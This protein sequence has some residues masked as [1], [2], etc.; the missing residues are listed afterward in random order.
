MNQQPTK[1]VR[2]RNPSS[3]RPSSLQVVLL[4]TVVIAVA[5]IALS[6]QAFIAVHAFSVSDPQSSRSVSKVLVTGAAGKT[7]RLVLSKLEQDPRYEP[8]ALVR[9]ERSAR[10]LVYNIKENRNADG[11]PLQHCPLEHILI[12]DIT[13]PTFV[14]TTSQI[15]GLVHDGGIEAMIICTSSVPQIQKRSVIKMLLKAPINILRR[16]PVVDFRSLTFRWK[17]G[18]RGY[19]QKVD[20]DGQ[21]AQIQLAKALGIRHVVLVS[22]MGVT[23][24][25]NFLNSVGKNNNGKKK[26]A[27]AGGDGD[28]GHGDILIWKRRA[29][30][31]LVEESG[32]D[33][34]IIHPG[35]L[36]DTPGG[37]EEFVLDVD[38]NL[39]NQTGVIRKTRIS[40]EDVADLCVAALSVGKNRKVSFDCITRPIFTASDDDDDDDDIDSTATITAATKTTTR[41]SAE[42]ALSK[43]LELSKTADYA[44]TM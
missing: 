35:G 12:A 14:E 30:K 21:I 4:A 17:G 1:T 6:F 24:P 28:A 44:T 26:K 38:D 39:Y 20:Y 11:Q 40:R 25:N 9:S 29:E 41:S 42:E 7:G 31:Y 16:K 34:T 43:F 37:I 27:S 13:S 8:K 33:Y 22:S 23:D 32:L 19:P 3:T 36:V 10:K 15:P 5:G 2:R 18:D